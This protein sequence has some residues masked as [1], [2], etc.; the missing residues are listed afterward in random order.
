MV[1]GGNPEVQ[2]TNSDLELAGS[3][4]HHSCMADYFDIRRWTTLYRTDNIASLWWQ[5]KCSTISTSPPDHL[6]CLQAIHQRFHCYVPRHDFVSGVDKG[7]SERLSCSRDLTDAAFLT[8]MDALHP[9]EL[10]WRLWNP[11]RELVSSIY[12]A[13]RQTTSPKESMLANPPPPMYTG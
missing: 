4:I 8:H 6:L 1:Y 13:L 12:S 3:V 2:V 7:V 9:Q 11:P 10:T 5:S